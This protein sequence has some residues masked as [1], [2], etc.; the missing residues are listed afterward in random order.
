MN[1]TARVHIR[2]QQ[3]NGKK[4]VTLTRRYGLQEDFEMLKTSVKCGWRFT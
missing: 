3:R 2:V 4:C 1:H